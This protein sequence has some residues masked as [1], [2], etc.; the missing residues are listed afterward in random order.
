[1][2]FA[3]LVEATVYAPELDNKEIVDPPEV[4]LGLQHRFPNL[5][6]FPDRPIRPMHLTR[7]KKTYYCPACEASYEKALSRLPR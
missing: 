6:G 7:P 4:I 3:P 1:M 2:H 5:K